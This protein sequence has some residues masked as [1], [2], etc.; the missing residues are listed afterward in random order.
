MISSEDAPAFPLC[1]T[2]GIIGTGLIGGSMA[3]DIRH[4]GLSSALLGTNRR[5][6]SSDEAL[7]L[8]LID[9]AVSLDELL[10]ESELILLC[11]PA[12]AA[13]KMLPGILDRIGER[14][15]SASASARPQP[16]VLDVCSVKGVIVDAVKGHPFR[17]RYVAGHPMSGTEYSGPSAARED[18]FR[19][20]AGILCDAEDSDADAVAL[21]ERLYDAL[22]MRTVRMDSASHD[23]HTAYVSHL[24][25]VLSFALA[26]T[27]L[28][29]EKDDKHIFDLASGGFSSTVRL[30]K[31]NA[32][33]WV[34]VFSQNRE[35]LLGV[36]D[37]YLGR[38]MDF[39][40]AVEADDADALRSLIEDAN[41]IRRIIK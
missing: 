20:K 5:P 1:A 29:K 25:H 12:G 3:L 16:V 36:L 27:V 21:V 26:L 4:A 35:N 30:A 28:D 18:L 14:I 9:R 17:G 31:S 23:V 7:R 32:D 22:G 34:S 2:I 41:K 33:M 19:G 6:E 38:L 15:R 37:A 11:I 40:R 8:G 39:R 10:C 24:S 13:A